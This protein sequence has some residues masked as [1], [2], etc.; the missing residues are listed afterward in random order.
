V[1]IP[2]KHTPA[3]ASTLEKTKKMGIALRHYRDGL[4]PP[5]FHHD[6]ARERQTATRNRLI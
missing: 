5:T 1:N 2:I 6:G 4:K 3:V